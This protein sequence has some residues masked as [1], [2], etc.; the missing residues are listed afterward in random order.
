MWLRVSDSTLLPHW[1][2]AVSLYF[3]LHRPT[4]PTVLHSHW[5]LVNRNEHHEYR[6][7]LVSLR[8]SVTCVSEDHYIVDVDF[9]HWSCALLSSTSFVP[10]SL[11]LSLLFLSFAHPSHPPVLSSFPSLLCTSIAYGTI[12]YP[13]QRGRISAPHAHW[14]ETTHFRRPERRRNFLWEWNFALLPI[15]THT[16]YTHT[17]ELNLSTSHGLGDKTAV[18]SPSCRANQSWDLTLFKQNAIIKYKM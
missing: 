8:T 2:F 13:R 17:A 16:Q 5:K 12:V 10:P 15:D 6:H 1:S 3:R 18:T 11:S 14:I 4:C 7:A 9:Y